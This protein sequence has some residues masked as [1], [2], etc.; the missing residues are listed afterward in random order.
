MITVFRDPVDH[1][2]IYDAINAD[3]VVAAWFTGETG[4]LTPTTRKRE[5][6][7]KAHPGP[8]PSDE[9]VVRLS[10]L[11]PQTEHGVVFVFYQDAAPERKYKST[12]Y[13]RGT[14]PARDARWG[15]MVRK[16]TSP[17]GAPP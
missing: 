17:V 5:I 3:G 1:S 2:G 9:E 7:C 14:I 8:P 16:V 13:G 10:G 6:V 11:D 15:L 4:A 12:R